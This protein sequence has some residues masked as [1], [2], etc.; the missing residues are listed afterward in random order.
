MNLNDENENNDHFL[1]NM[2]TPVNKKDSSIYNSY[3]PKRKRCSLG[4]V[5]NDYYY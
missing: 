1:W 4:K 2:D 5:L 3:E